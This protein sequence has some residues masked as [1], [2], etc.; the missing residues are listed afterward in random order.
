MGTSD[1]KILP[2]GA[3]FRVLSPRFDIEALA[4]SVM[5][6]AAVLPVMAQWSLFSTLVKNG[7]VISALGE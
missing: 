3:F 5:I 7:F 1:F 4:R 2:P 6:S